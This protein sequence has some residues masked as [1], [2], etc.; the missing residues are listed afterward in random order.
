MILYLGRKLDISIHDG[1]GG[2]P[3]TAHRNSASK[4]FRDT[5]YNT[6]VV[7]SNC[8]KFELDMQNF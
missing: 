3:Q 7:A 1:R 4:I 8:G 6:V 2:L 5:N